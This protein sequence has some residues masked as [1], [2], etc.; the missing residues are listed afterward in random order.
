MLSGDEVYTFNDNYLL[1]DDKK[2]FIA[3]KRYSHDVFD[4]L[5]DAYPAEDVN[6]IMHPLIALFFSLFD[7]KRRVKDVIAKYSELTGIRFRNMSTF[8]ENVIRNVV[9]KE[10]GKFMKFG[11]HLFY[12]PKDIITKDQKRDIKDEIDVNDFLIPK[13]ELDL[14]SLR[15][16]SPLDCL[17]EVNFK[18]VTDCIYCY[19]DRRN[20]IQ[21]SIPINRLK[22]IIKEAKQLK[23]RTFE[24]SGGELFLYD[25]W[26]IL[27][28]ELLDN[29]FRPYISTKIPL[30]REVI[31]KLKHLGMKEIQL[32]I[33]SIRKDELK[34]ILKVNQDYQ[35]RITRTLKLL[36]KEGFTIFIN[37]QITRSN[38]SPKGVKEML[39][40]FLGLNNIRSIKFG[41]IGYSLYKSTEHFHM[42]SPRI[43]NLHKI[44]EL[45]NEYKAKHNNIIINFSGYSSNKKYINEFS[46]KE[47]SYNDRVRCSGNFYAFVIMPDGKVTI[48][49]ELYFHPKFIIGDLKK[50]SIQEVWNSKRAQDLY[51]FSKEMISDK[52]ACK[53]CDKNEDCHSLKGV[54]WKEILYAYGYKNW[55][56]PDPKCP[57]APQ[58]YNKIWID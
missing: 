3:L 18:C 13:K 29:D 24:L 5:N 49:E 46:E 1:K 51:Q 38:D 50:Q 28:K 4:K 57:Y 41:A 56:Y 19:A 37:G 44:E 48:C 40:F 14:K 25:K 17:F 23:M 53:T 32:S 21:C 27:L 7:G 35:E 36:D 42:I 39:D 10:K 47:K 31:I 52:S 8:T 55:D 6:V 15:T 43:K 33:D 58:P 22:E 12:I 2:R 30:S 26:E 9:N 20:K 45:F 11:E 16:Y 34:E 54:C